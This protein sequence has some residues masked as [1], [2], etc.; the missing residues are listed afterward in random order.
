MKN[1]GQIKFNVVKQE[2]L[3]SE[4]AA[5]HLDVQPQGIKVKTGIKAGGNCW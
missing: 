5:S 1:N 3:Q 4:P 2:V